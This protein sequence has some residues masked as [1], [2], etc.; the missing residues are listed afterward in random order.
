MSPSDPVSGHRGA[1]L[2][3]EA[4]EA[5][6]ARLAASHEDRE[7]HQ[8]LPRR[9]EE[10]WEVVKVALPPPADTLKAEI[11]ADER[12]ETPD[13]PRTSQQRNAPYPAG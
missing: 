7:T 6:C 12:P 8:W 13:D 2:T 4:A 1:P 11:R 9:T 3:K 10:G 5:L